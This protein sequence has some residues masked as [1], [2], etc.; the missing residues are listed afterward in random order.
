MAKRKTTNGKTHTRSALER[1]EHKTNVRF[2]AM[3]RVIGSGFAELSRG[4]TDL[5]RKVD[6]QGEFL[7]QI[8]ASARENAK[9]AGESTALLRELVGQTKRAAELEPRV[10]RCE[11]EIDELKKKPQ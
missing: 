6:R 3:E 11:A 9:L 7:G 8:V 10:A 4:L 5:G 2:L 1:L